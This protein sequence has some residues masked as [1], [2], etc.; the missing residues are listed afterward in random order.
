MDK[1]RAYLISNFT[2][3]YLLVFI[4]F[5]MI[6]SLVFIIQISVLSSKIELKASEL[7]EFFIYMLP[8]IFFYTI[9]FSLMASLATTFTKLSEENE[10]IALF[11]L[12]HTPSKIL[13]YMLPIVTLFSI[14]LLVLSIMLFPQMKQ[15]IN[16]F[17]RE[18][19]TQATLISLQINLVI[20]WR[21]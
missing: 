16:N 19:I 21:L 8:N 7:I 5:M 6:V 15:K 12:G 4:P 13:L 9:P 17:K 14:L 11:S 3:T 18:K 20:F 2:K 1:T 10:L